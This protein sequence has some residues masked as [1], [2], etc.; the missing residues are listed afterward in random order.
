M[1][2]DVPAL[3]EGGTF[4]RVLQRQNLVPARSPVHAICRLLLV[5]QAC[6]KLRPGWLPTRD[7]AGQLQRPGGA[8]PAKRSGCCSALQ[9]RRVGHKRQGAQAIFFALFE[10]LD[11][12]YISWSS[13]FCK[14]DLA[15]RVS[16][17]TTTFIGHAGEGYVV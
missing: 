7:P 17:H 5:T 3:P 16:A 2:A 9:S 15:F 14:D 10:N 6:K 1:L 12:G 13:A 11:I 4:Q 8:T